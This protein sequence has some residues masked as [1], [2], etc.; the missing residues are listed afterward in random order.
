MICSSDLHGKRVRSESGAR[1][2]RVFE[3]HVKQ[4]QVEA[5]ICGGGAFWQRLMS[6]HTGHRVPWSRVSKL[7]KEIVIAD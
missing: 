5:L 4:G 2:G 3:I 7:G 1:F 6:A